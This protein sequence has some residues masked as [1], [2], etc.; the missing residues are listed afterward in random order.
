MF[1]IA[2]FFIMC[3]VI[4]LN[5]TCAKHL[6]TWRDNSFLQFVFYNSSLKFVFTIRLSKLVFHNPLF[7]PSNFSLLSVHFSINFV[8]RTRLPFYKSKS[9][10]VC[11]VCMICPVKQNNNE[12]GN[13]TSVVE[14]PLQNTKFK[15]TQDFHEISRKI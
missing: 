3:F 2:P 5:P 14:G 7:F 11:G 4:R 13:R 6:S 1:Q 10:Q 9:F 12:S 8:P 15:K